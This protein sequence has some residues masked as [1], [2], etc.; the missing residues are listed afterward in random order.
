MMITFISKQWLSIPEG[1]LPE[2]WRWEEAYLTIT[3]F[4]ICLRRAD[5]EV[6]R[7]KG[8]REE[9]NSLFLP[10]LCVC[11]CVLFRAGN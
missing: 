2:L 3:F 6:L 10:P 5:R 11:V 4:N 9:E 7:E 1:N 8:D